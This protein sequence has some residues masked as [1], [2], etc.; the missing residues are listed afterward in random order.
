[1]NKLKINELT[2]LSD[3]GKVRRV[4]GGFVYIEET[5]AVFV[6]RKK[7]VRKKVDKVYSEELR[8]MMTAVWNAYPTGK[9]VS[10]PMV[11]QCMASINPDKAIVINI[12]K[13]IETKKKTT[14]WLDN[15]GKYIPMLTTYLNQRRW[16]DGN[17]IKI[18]DKWET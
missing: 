2:E 7:T 11:L 1:M 13:D 4:H 14:N 18:T 10:K 8:A 9:R 17:P 12:I 6:P 5:G 16:Q 15:N 3:G